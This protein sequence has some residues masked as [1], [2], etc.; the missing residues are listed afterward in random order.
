M[1]P[2]DVLGRARDAFQRQQWGE[3]YAQF[4]AADHDAPLAPPD[5][6]RLA[7][8]AYLLGRDADSEAILERA[9]QEYLEQQEPAAAARCAFWLAFGLLDRGEHA[10][11]SGWMARARR[12]LDEAGRDCVERGY[13]LLPRG[14]EQFAQGDL[15]GAYATFHEAAGIGARFEDADLMAIARQGQGRALL[16]GGAVEDGV[17]LLDEVMVAALAGEVSPVVVGTVYCSVIS[18]C[19]EIFDLR[20]AHE[21]TEALSRWCEAQ[22]DLVAYRGQCMVH[23]AEVLQLRGSWADALDEARKATM[24]LA[25]PPGQAGVAAAHYRQAE[26]HRVRGEFEEAEHAYRQAGESGQKLQP[27]LALLRLAQGRI[28]AASAAIHRMADEASERRAR[29]PVLAALVEIALEEHDLPTARA[30][31]AELSEV[32]DDLR[33]PYLHALAAQATGAVTL[34]DG[35]A[36]AALPALRS[37]WAGW[38]QLGAPYEAARVRALIGVACRTLGDEDAAAMELDAATAAFSELGATWDLDRVARLTRR[39][40]A[41]SADGL[42]PR[43]RQVL[44]LVAAGKTNRRIALDLEISEKTVARHVSNIFN[45]LGVST[46]SAATA[47]AYQHDLA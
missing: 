13:L 37:A 26:L 43:E 46:R 39:S 7:T 23:R 30:A 28:D 5:L 15:D 34:A 3:A 19:R 44:R 40:S 45:K 6:E 4:S 24:R 1:T 20:R 32:A 42:T 14:I 10:R 41:T 33:M 16:R 36:R 9:H 27:G 12:V 11:G 22:P 8:A 17:T 47:Y 18:A 21:W 31:A 35:D 25:D 29:P 38:E 2:P